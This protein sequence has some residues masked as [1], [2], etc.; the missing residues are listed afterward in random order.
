ML[1]DTSEFLGS[2]R[3][4][5][6]ALVHP[7]AISK[8]YLKT[9]F[10][11]YGMSV[12]YAFLKEHSVPVLQYDFLME[13]LFDSPED[14]D[15]HSPANSFSEE[16]FFSLLTCDGGRTS[17]RSNMEIAVETLLGQRTSLIPISKDSIS[18]SQIGFPGGE[19]NLRSAYKVF[20]E[21]YGEDLFTKRSSPQSLA[22]LT[23]FVEKYGNRIAPDAGIYAFSIVAYHQFWA[24]LLLARYIR[25]INPRAVIV[26]GGPF[27]TIKPAE[28]FVRF[29]IADY[30]V[31]GSGEVPLLMLHALLMGRG[32]VTKE[33]IPGLIYVE[34]GEIHQA[35]QSEFPAE[36]ERAP[37]FEGLRLDDYRYDHPLTGEK[38]FFLPYRL[39]KGCPSRCSFCTGRL[40]DRYD[41]K[42]VD[43][44]L[45]E[46]TL[47]TSRYGTNNFQF[48]DASINGNPRQ[49]SEICRRLSSELPDIRWYSY[50]K[51]NGFSSGL[52]REVK[53]AGC[54]AL[55]WG[56]ESGHQPTIK[57]LGKHFDVGEMY[58][59]LND[60]V[61]A[62]IKNYVH[63]IYNTPHESQETLDCFI[64]LVERYID[65]DMVVFLP[66]RFLLEPQSLM[67]DHPE[68]YALSNVRRVE[69]PIFEREQYV[70]DE[71]QGP[72]HPH[73]SERNE[74]HRDFL[75]SHLQ[76][77]QYRNMM[78]AASNGKLNRLIPRLLLRSWRFSRRFPW[79]EG[80]HNSLVRRLESRGNAIKEQL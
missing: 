21:G 75:A 30:W 12:I 35:E 7:P 33:Q 17:S 61:A 10:M 48:A 67:F 49:L 74:R 59:L 37:D 28:S 16:D 64:Q 14:V 24:A 60:A 50:G 54:F 4:P 44:V 72:D 23:A 18:G 42:S 53:E 36:A 46:L 71:I 25:E 57:L 38:T 9:K 6:V 47:L 26:F 31:K 63:L 11:P 13:Y 5:R 27:I 29:G 69:A 39:S 20:G 41:Y 68:R 80:L 73:I 55:F 15:F 56:V 45:R 1:P 51:V 34:G 40:V 43:K 3:D 22:G 66:Q 8:R 65:S 2:E 77:I 62:G 76:L 32:S 19:T 78:L 79:L 52:L 70:F 58:K